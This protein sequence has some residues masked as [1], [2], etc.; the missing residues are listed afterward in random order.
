MTA[1]VGFSR[2]AH[3]LASRLGMADIT[4]PWMAGW[5]ASCTVTISRAMWPRLPTGFDASVSGLGSV[6][7]CS[8]RSRT[9]P[10]AATALIHFGP[11]EREHKCPAADAD[12]IHVPSP[13]FTGPNRFVALAS[14]ALGAAV[15]TAGR[16]G[17]EAAI[18]A[19]SGPAS[20]RPGAIP[21]R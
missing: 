16:S 4:L 7:Y 13:A 9:T 5:S 18:V 8:N 1:C 14:G 10:A 21:S 11:G 3:A 2:E 19:N 6:V 15:R 17:T 12:R 20:T